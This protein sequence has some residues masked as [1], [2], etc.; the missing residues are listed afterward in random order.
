[1]PVEGVLYSIPLISTTEATLPENFTWPSM[2][3]A[4]VLMTPYFMIEAMSST[5]TTSAL[6]PC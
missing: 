3:N 1:M 2:T 5:F 4:G 6:T